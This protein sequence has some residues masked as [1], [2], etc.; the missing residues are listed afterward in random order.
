MGYAVAAVLG[1]LLGCVNPAYIISRRRNADL[2]SAGSRNLG[3]SNTALLLGW[4]LGIGVAILDAS[5]A[6]L[7]V[8]L[9]KLL[10]PEPEAIGY[11]A[12]VACVMG[13]IFPFWLGFRGGKGLASFVGMTL[14]LDWKLG[15]ALLLLGAVITIVTDYIVL[16]T[17]TY[18]FTVPVYTF[19]TRGWLCA[20]IIAAATAVIFWRH[21]ENY[22]RILR[23][24]EY[25]LRSALR[26]ENR[27]N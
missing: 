14:L 3:A 22:V 17:L 7:A 23:G 1:Y 15:V 6:A 9:A 21:R 27:I 26:K 12:G 10:F 2:T 20:L 18:I 4:R 5:K 8:I 13:H 25:G 24:T 19:F 16:G 11:V